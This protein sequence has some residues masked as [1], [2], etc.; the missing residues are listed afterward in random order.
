MRKTSRTRT[1]RWVR[2]YLLLD[3]YASSE[4]PVKCEKKCRLLGATND[5]VAKEPMRGLR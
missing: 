5:C 1:V 3:V 2:V 4:S